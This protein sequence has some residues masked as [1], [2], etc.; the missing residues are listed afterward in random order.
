MTDTTSQDSEPDIS[1]PRIATNLED[2]NG[3]MPLM[4]PSMVFINGLPYDR[5]N[6]NGGLDDVLGKGVAA[7]T[8][9][10]G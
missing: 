5:S 10:R 3:G 4:S 7:G 2:D 1:K 6:D 8:A 9:P